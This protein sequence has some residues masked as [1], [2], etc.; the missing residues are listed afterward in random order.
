MLTSPEGRQGGHGASEG[1]S[2]W[3]PLTAAQRA[4]R[5]SARA[6]SGDVR[7]R[8]EW[9]PVPLPGPR[10]GG[11]EIT[12]VDSGD[13]ELEAPAGPTL[14]ASPRFKRMRAK[15]RS[16]H[17]EPASADAAEARVEGLD[18]D[19]PSAAMSTDAS[20]FNTDSYDAS[21]FESGGDINA[22]D[23]DDG[24]IPV[25]TSG[26]E[27][28]EARRKRDRKRRKP[29][30]PAPPVPVPVPVPAVPPPVPLT[31]PAPD[32]DAP[33]HEIDK[34]HDAV[35]VPEFPTELWVGNIAPEVTQEGLAALFTHKAVPPTAVILSDASTGRRSHKYAVVTLPSQQ[36]AHKVRSRVRVRVCVRLHCA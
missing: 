25:D 17:R 35:R 28:V 23:E 7:A 20:D 14:P 18:G 31:H 24:V 2:R 5:L 1:G 16:R 3:R 4:A 12:V 30:L 32:P 8:D 29:T 21:A 34:L 10:V 36:H 9:P 19:P 26:D 15:V 13:D 11:G 27:R 6:A 22:D 33:P